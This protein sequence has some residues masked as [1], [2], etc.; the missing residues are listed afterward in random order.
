MSQRNGPDQGRPIFPLRFNPHTHAASAVRSVFITLKS[1]M[2]RE[3][4]GRAE[5]SVCW[6]FADENHNPV[7]PDHPVSSL[8]EP[9]RDGDS[10]L[11]NFW[12][13]HTHRGRAE[14]LDSACVH[15]HRDCAA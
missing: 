6:G 4:T 1:E 11:A 14:F 2:R 7:D 9:A 15:A 10:P 8:A 12:P 5:S 13:E 3:I